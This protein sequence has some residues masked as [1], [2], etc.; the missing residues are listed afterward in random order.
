MKALVIA[1]KDAPPVLT[2]VADPVAGPG[3]AIV[4]VHAAALNH[5]D[6]WIQRGQYAGLRWPII[7]GSDG[8]GVVA[9]VGPGAGSAAGVED[10]SA[11]GSA[12]GTG[13]AG[14][15]W[16][17]KA[18]IIDPSIGWGEDEGFQS[19]AGYAVLGLP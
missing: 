1:V 13:S 5:R 9:A 15:E 16:I 4:R 8:A 3:E 19:P 10:A 14:G 11:A 17:G 6:V 7:V 2:S 12:A 18:V